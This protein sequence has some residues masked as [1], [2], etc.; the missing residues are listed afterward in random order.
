MDPG[1]RPD[2]GNP[3]GRWST[4]CRKKQGTSYLPDVDY[5]QKRVRRSGSGR[6]RPWQQQQQEFPQAHHH[7]RPRENHFG[8]YRHG[9]VIPKRF[10]RWRQSSIYSVPDDSEVR[11]Q[12]DPLFKPK[13]GI[14]FKL[15]KAQHHMNRLTKDTPPN[16]INNFTV[17]LGRKITPAMASDFIHKE[18]WDNAR[19]WQKSTI[20]SLKEHFYRVIKEQLALLLD[21]PDHEWRLPFNRA[22]QWAKT[23]FGKHLLHSTLTQVE[24]ILKQGLEGADDSPL[25]PTEA[26]TAARPWSPVTHS[27][28][29][30]GLLKSPM[31][32]E[33]QFTTIEQLIHTLT[34]SLERINSIIPATT[35]QKPELRTHNSN[36][37]TVTAEPRTCSRTTQTRQA[38][39][40]ITNRTTQTVTT[41]LGTCNSTTQTVTEDRDTQ[42]RATQTVKLVRSRRIQA[43]DPT[44]H[45][46][47]A[48]AQTEHL[49]SRTREPLEP[50]PVEKRTPALGGQ[51]RRGDEKRHLETNETGMI[52]RCLQTDPR[53]P[54]E[55][56]G[57]KPN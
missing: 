10:T 51:Q 42:H 47:G 11:I 2:D 48:T 22:S 23:N 54:I 18:I 26:E 34:C 9:G 46:R 53:K 30:R 55:R 6:F 50:G 1:P 41:E 43:G 29:T 21:L 44:G 5:V 40:S 52:D 4:T 8:F 37:Q 17:M 15:I 7:K 35:E 25:Q 19:N 49:P 32:K 56:W 33:K 45:L 28:T 3:M 12:H 57:F 13:V 24:R 39:R 27:P 14:I 16:F 20:L 36:T 31:L 38:E